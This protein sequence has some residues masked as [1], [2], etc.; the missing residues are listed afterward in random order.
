MIKYILYVNPYIE[1]MKGLE[2]KNSL[3]EEFGVCLF[4]HRKPQSFFLR[5]YKTK[6]PNK[7]LHRNEYIL[8]FNNSDN[9]TY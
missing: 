9:D 8:C 1:I 4:L 7:Q 2:E 6:E 3:Q 5:I